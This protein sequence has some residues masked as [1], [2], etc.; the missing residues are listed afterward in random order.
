M[1]RV[2]PWHISAGALLAQLPVTRQCLRKTRDWRNRARVT[3][4]PDEIEWR[5]EPAPVPYDEAIAVME[6]RAA[7]VD[8]G[9]ARDLI[10]L[11]EPPPV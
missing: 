10:W 8:A 11:L 9:E 3:A 1:R 7:A 6:A 4:L 5:V 2:L